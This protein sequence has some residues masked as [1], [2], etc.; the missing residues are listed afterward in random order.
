[1]TFRAKHMRKPGKIFFPDQ[2]TQVCN[3]E[4]G[5]GKPTFI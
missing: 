5:H 1:M 2:P 4:L 3:L